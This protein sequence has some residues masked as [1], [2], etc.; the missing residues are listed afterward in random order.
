MVES[1]AVM[2]LRQFPVIG[3]MILAAAVFSI[4]IVGSA[5]GQVPGMTEVSGEYT[6]DEFGVEFVFPD[7]WEGFEIQSERA[8]IV[9]TVKG[10]ISNENPTH[11]MTLTIAEK[12][13]ETDPTD[14]STYTQDEEVSCGES[15]VGTVQVSDK[16]GYEV[17]TECTINGTPT[18]IKGI[19]IRTETHWILLA[20]MAPSSEFGADEATFDDAVTTLQVEGAMDVDTTG[21]EP[22]PDEEQTPTVEL[23]SVVQSV[24][25]GEKSIDLAVKTSSTISDFEI[26]EEN[27]MISFTVDGTTGTEGTTEIPIGQILEGPFTVMID[28]Q[29]TTDFEVTGEG[30]ADAV[31]TIS[32][33]HSVHDITITGTNVVPEFPAV[34]VGI[35]AA[36]V[37]I[38]A[39]M[40]RTNLLNRK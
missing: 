26:D 24:M 23:T 31:I 8:V 37:G 33:M 15:S 18:T 16:I 20:Y 3:A 10:G 19:S 14:P 11:L 5:V 25:I 7:G 4:P 32:Y 39:V 28:G 35:I 17:T 30:T 22:A 12:S 9:S 34:I 1:S 13:E 29:S 38:V 40:G 6:N 21:T 27:K 36:I 2:N